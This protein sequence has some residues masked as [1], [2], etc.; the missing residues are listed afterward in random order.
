ML[1]CATSSPLLPQLVR[2]LC[3][4]LAT[5]GM[6]GIAHLRRWPPPRKRTRVKINWSEAGECISVF[7]AIVAA[8][9][10]L[11][12]ADRSWSSPSPARSTQHTSVVCGTV[13]TSSNS[14]PASPSL[15][16]AGSV[17]PDIAP[18]PPTLNT[19]PADFT[20]SPVANSSPEQYQ[21]LPEP[22]TTNAPEG[23]PVDNTCD[24][25]TWA[26]SP[27]P[28][29]PHRRPHRSVRCVTSRDNAPSGA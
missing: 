23:R 12:V 5:E 2:E 13:S 27:T 6:F 11:W 7:A 24:W 21:Q 28:P 9:T 18:P 26:S 22:A 19:S 4:T 16:A 14:R 15:P 20:A 1:G 29:S 8:V 17:R 3:S 25:L 10:F